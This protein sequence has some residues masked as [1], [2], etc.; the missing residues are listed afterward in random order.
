MM[1]KKLFSIMLLVLAALVLAMAPAAQAASVDI[2]MENWCG[3]GRMFSVDRNAPAASLT[4]T[5]D[6]SG[7]GTGYYLE[8]TATSTWLGAAATVGETNGGL[9]V[10]P[11]GSNNRLKD[12]SIIYLDMKIKDG[13]DQDVTANYVF[14]I[15]D[16]QAKAN[17]EQSIL[18]IEVDGTTTYEFHSASTSHDVIWASNTT[19]PTYD[20]PDPSSVSFAPSGNPNIQLLFNFNGM[21]L[22]VTDDLAAAP[23]TVIMFK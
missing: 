8:I 5:A 6:A 22:T 7:L 23:G 3:P 20:V 1:K 13:S 14:E 17:K 19:V 15:T 2:T 16:L 21:K 12:G 10:P 11:A 9:T 4:G 18:A